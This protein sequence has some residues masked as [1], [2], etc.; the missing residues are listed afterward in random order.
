MNPITNMNVNTNMNT[1]NT[2]TP[3][4]PV[5]KRANLTID[6]DQHSHGLNLIS[7]IMARW[8]VSNKK[9]FAEVYGAASDA[10]QRLVPDTRYSCKALLV[11]DLW[12][13]RPTDGQ[14]RAMGIA[15][16]KLVKSGH[17]P[18]LFVKPDR[19]NKRY[20]L[21]SADTVNAWKQRSKSAVEQCGQVP[22]KA[23]A[24]I[25]CPRPAAPP[26]ATDTPQARATTPV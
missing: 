23:A 25:K 21:A 14:H 24:Q 22:V 17:L 2:P 7:E 11:K 9:L 16:S 19:S 3:R 20:V 5:I 18:L 26:T 15:L 4:I 6:L 1:T 12:K 10:V 13:R 8:G